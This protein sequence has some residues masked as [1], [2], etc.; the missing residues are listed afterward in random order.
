MKIERTKNAYR[1]IIFGIVLKIYQIIIPFLIRTVMIWFIGV[2]YIGL[3]GLFTSILQVLNLTELGVGSAMVYSMYKPIA[4]DDIP[5]ICKLLNLYKKYY[6]IIGCIIL[7]IGIIMTPIIPHLINDK[8]PQDINIYYLYWFNLAATVCSYWLF[9]YKNSILQAHQRVDILSKVTILTSTVQYIFQFVAICV[10]KNYYF[11]VITVLVGQVLTNIFT[12]IISTICYPNY[13]AEGKLEKNIVD[14]INQRIKDL[15]TSKVGSVVVNSVDT[16]VISAFLGLTILGMYQNYYFIITAIIGFM[17]VIFAACMAG[18]GNS[19]IVE[20]KLKNF[21]DLNK[22]TFIIVWITGVGSCCLI[23]VLQEFIELWVG[24]IY[25]F[26]YK[27]V[28]CFCV[29]FYIYEVNRLLN[30]YKDAG[31]IWHQDRFRPLVTAF[32]NMGM[33]L[34]TVKFWGVYGVLISTVLSMLIVGMPWIM[35]NLFTTLFEEEQLKLY[36][37][38]LL[39]YTMGV[40]FICGICTNIINNVLNFDGLLNIFLRVFSCTVIFNLFW[41]LLFGKTKECKEGLNLVKGLL[42]KKSK[43]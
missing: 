7:V 39:V 2:E 23:N 18:I 43:N 20:S 30:T 22:F 11:F 36:L 12:A 5:Q 41:L 6:N 8:V 32:V 14:D 40:V 19:L 25:I 4:D 26:D 13:K 1:N 16:L 42:L 27:V 29:Y 34:L 33:N 17:D 38:K 24:D 37:K 31:G 3:N 9:S 21:N 28:I 10:Y 35:K 15:F